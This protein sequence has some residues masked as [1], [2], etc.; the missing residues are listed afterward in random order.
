MFLLYI[1]LYFRI[2][3]LILTFIF[4]M[5]RVTTFAGARNF[6][7]ILLGNQTIPLK[8][9]LILAPLSPSHL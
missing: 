1:I 5:V 4:Y 9:L 7:R 6:F 8:A 3:T 2:K